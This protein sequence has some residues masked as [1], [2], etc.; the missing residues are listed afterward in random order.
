MIITLRDYDDGVSM[1]NAYAGLLGGV[2][3][4]LGEDVYILPL[5]DMPVRSTLNLVIGADNNHDAMKNTGVDA[6]ID[7]ISSGVFPNE[8]AIKKKSEYISKQGHKYDIA[9][10]TSKADFVKNLPDNARYVK[11]LLKAL[12]GIYSLTIVILNNLTD[13]VLFGEEKENIESLISRNVMIVRQGTWINE[14]KRNMYVVTPKDMVVVSDFQPESK[15]GISQMRA[16]LGIPKKTQM[17][18]LGINTEL[19]D[20]I[21]HCR[22]NDDFVKRYGGASP[23]YNP[24]KNILDDCDR[25]IMDITGKRSEEADPYGEF[26]QVKHATL[27]QTFADRLKGVRPTGTDEVTLRNA[28]AERRE[29]EYTVYEK[30]QTKEVVYRKKVEEKQEVRNEMLNV[31]DVD[32]SQLRRAPEP[33]QPQKRSLFGGFGR[34]PV[35]RKPEPVPEELEEPEEVAA[36][37]PEKK[38]VVKKVVKRR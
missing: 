3:N 16:R 13:D 24:G 8:T 2:A 32:V 23:E 10:A 31:N 21:H 6:L 37:V 26:V 18:T 36:P 11:T 35:Q 14:K 28:E 22:V 9:D 30:E 17:H 20:A 29:R 38:K 33:E 5:T 27:K 12:D 34:K 4:L 25:I 19:L 7:M 1:L 15:Y